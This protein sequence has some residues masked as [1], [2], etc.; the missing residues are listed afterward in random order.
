MNIL[1]AEELVETDPDEAAR[2][3]N[4]ALNENPDD[5]QALYI[6]GRCFAAGARYGAAAALYHRILALEPNSSGAWNNLGHAYHTVNYLKEAEIC[7][8]N[9]RK[10]DPSNYHAYNNL[11]AVNA[12]QCKAEEALYWSTKA[13]HAAQG[14]PDYIR[15]VRENISLPLLGTG[16]FEDG[17][18]AFRAGIGGKWR[19]DLRYGAE[20]LW[21]GE[22]GINLVVY[23]EQGIGDEIM[24]GSILPDVIRDCNV[25][26]ECDGRLENLFKTTFPG[27]PVYGTR[28]EG[29]RSWI[30]QH[31][32]DARIGMGQLGQYYRYSKEHFPRKGYLKTK[33]LNLERDKPL[34]G[35]AWT[36]GTQATRT[37]ERSLTLEQ[38]CWLRDARPDLQFVSL[39]YKGDECPEGILNPVMLTRDKDYIRTASLVNALDK[40]VS[41]TTAVAL[42][43]GALGK[44]CH[45]IVPPQPTWHWGYEGEMP[46]FDINLYRTS[47]AVGEAMTDIAEAL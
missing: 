42:L 35:I 17:W 22:H 3:C 20:P 25:I 18:K 41:V 47:G 9:A 19:K 10:I 43:A 24:F 39:E 36:G 31:K 34:V 16:R 5:C 46:W 6:L 12:A 28:L 27:I 32:I 26:I 44:E 29:D 7:F 38:V 13:I 11:T 1:E 8:H 45:V 40:V 14:N 4:L 15:S 30:T 37:K 2:L 21:T 33:P 23:G